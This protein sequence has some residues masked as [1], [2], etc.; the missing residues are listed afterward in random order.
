VYACDCSRRTIEETGGTAGGE[1]RYPGTC[2]R[3]RLPFAN[4]GVGL[5]VSMEPG[6]ER[7]EDA[8]LGPQAQDP[9]AQCGDLLV[10][11]RV[12][13]WTY[14]FAVTVDD[15][16]HGID[17]VIRG[18]D[19]LPS[20][21]RQI[22]L[23]RLLDRTHAP[24]FLHH[25]LVYAATGEK[26]SKSNRDAGLRELRASGVA[27]GRVL[28]MAAAASGLLSAPRDL[29]IDELPALFAAR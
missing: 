17:L 23:A 12:G 27:P 2:R 18:E 1:L 28:G 10:R 26:L 25:P 22:R 9:S 15:L 11:D 19:L 3:R 13:Q 4:E 6:V 5:R 20:T 24:V 7:F 16:T 29:T 14:Q 8:V 21:G